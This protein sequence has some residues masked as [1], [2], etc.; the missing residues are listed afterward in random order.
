MRE[1]EIFSDF[2]RYRRLGL[3]RREAIG[4]AIMRYRVQKLLAQHERAREIAK[5]ELRG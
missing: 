4:V 5:A 2:K 3:K 1:L